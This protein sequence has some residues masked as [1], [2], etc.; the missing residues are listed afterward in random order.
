MSFDTLH[1][2]IWRHV[3]SFLTPPKRK[4]LSGLTKE[5]AMSEMPTFVERLPSAGAAGVTSRSDIRAEALATLMRVS[6]VGLASRRRC[7][8]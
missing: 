3:L 6:V 7:S 1:T 4:P 8:S 2:D 5:E